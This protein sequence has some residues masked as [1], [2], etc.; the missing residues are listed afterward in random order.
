MVKEFFSK[1]IFNKRNA[2]SF[3]LITRSE[4]ERISLEIYLISAT[5]MIHHVS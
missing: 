1:D 2:I 5:F 3:K 4:T